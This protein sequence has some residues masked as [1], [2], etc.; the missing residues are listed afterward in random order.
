MTPVRE[1]A[2]GE[3]DNATKKTILSRLA[4]EALEPIILLL[5][6]TTTTATYCSALIG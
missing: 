1:G 5:K 2:H 6:T 4:S 3:V